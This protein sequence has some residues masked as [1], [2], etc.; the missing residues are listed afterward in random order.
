MRFTNRI[1]ERFP[2]LH[3]GS[4][5]IFRENLEYITKVCYMREETTI[6]YVIEEVMY[7]N[8]K[9]YVLEYDNNGLVS[10][11]TFNSYSMKTVIKTN[12]LPFTDFYDCEEFEYYVK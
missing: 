12:K 7:D 6:I 3:N 1:V 9:C 10:M 4:S 2:F 11:K 5:S 8:V